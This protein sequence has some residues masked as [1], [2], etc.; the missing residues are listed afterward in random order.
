[1]TLA[2]PAAEEVI[3]TDVLG[4]K[5]TSAARREGLLVEFD[6]SGLS[7]KRFAKLHQ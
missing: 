6:K 7:A 1:M 3:N 2:T 4:R 5:R